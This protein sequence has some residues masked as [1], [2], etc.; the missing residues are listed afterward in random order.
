MRIFK[1]MMRLARDP[2]LILCLASLLLYIS[3][4]RSCGSCLYLRT[5]W[6][7]ASFPVAASLLLWLGRPGYVLGVVVS[8]LAFCLSAF[9][10]L[11]ERGYAIADYGSDGWMQPAFMM[12]W[13]Y[14]L[15]MLLSAVIVWYAAASLRRRSL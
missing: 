4:L 9:N 7:V 11:K 12:S 5:A 2:R 10:V 3:V 8:S 6:G 14:L 15:V 13:G 1:Q